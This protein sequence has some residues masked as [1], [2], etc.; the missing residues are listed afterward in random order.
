MEIFKSIFSSILV[1]TEKKI[2]VQDWYNQTK[3]MTIDDFKND[4]L[5][6][7]KA[8]EEHKPKRVLVLQ[9]NFQFIVTLEL[10]NWVVNNVAIKLGQIKTE[11]VAIVVSEDL[12][13]SVSVEQTMEEKA[14]TGIEIKYFDEE[15]QAREWINIIN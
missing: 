12:F 6:L 11:K 1:D 8:Y 13:A 9:K 2:I 10:Q 15:Q 4:M 7:A 5:A 14:D 3:D